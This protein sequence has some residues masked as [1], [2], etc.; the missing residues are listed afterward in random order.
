[1]ALE[2]MR[3]TASVGSWIFG[4]GTSS[5]RT[6]RLPCHVNA[7]MCLAASRLG[8][9]LSPYPRRRRLSPRRPVQPDPGE[10]HVVVGAL[11]DQAAEQLVA[12]LGQRQVA[13]LADR[14][15]QLV[16]AVVEVLATAFH[17]T[18]GV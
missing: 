16:Q 9:S 3:T 2:V 18:I 12:Q 15:Q 14:R 4:S 8:G 6:S 17:Q 5:T 10:G 11:R 7:F 1:M 13:E